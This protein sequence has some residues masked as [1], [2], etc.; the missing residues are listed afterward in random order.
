MTELECD[1][2]VVGG[3]VAGSSAA[4]SSALNGA[5]TIILEKNFD[6]IKPACAEALTRSFLS[7]LPFKFPKIQLKLKIDGIK[8]YADE[9]SVTR[10]GELREG[11]S[12]ERSEIN[13]WLTNQAVNAGAKLFTN[14]EMIN[15]ESDDKGYITKIIAKRNDEE[16]KKSEQAPL[17]VT[18]THTIDDF[19]EIMRIIGPLQLSLKF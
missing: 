6:T 9:L 15:L 8:F 16:I 2:L 5:R 1:V 17:L 18:P 14:T 12:I 10:K 13:P 3:G 19:S 7:L 11:F 4:R